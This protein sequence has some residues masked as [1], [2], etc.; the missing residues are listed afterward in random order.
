MSLRGK[1]MVNANN[2]GKTTNNKIL[3]F[4]TLPHNKNAPPKKAGPQ[5]KIHMRNS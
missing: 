1:Y 5:L 4:F 3:T 2:K